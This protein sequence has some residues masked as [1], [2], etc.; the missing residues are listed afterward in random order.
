[1]AQFSAKAAFTAMVTASRFNTGRAPGKPRHTGQTLELG[2]SPKW[3]ESEQKIFVLVRS[4]RWTSRPITA[5]YLVRTTVET[6]ISRFPY[7]GFAS[8]ADYYTRD[9]PAIGPSGH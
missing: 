5:S 1:M 2:G 3:V 7:C 4:C 8:P 6:V 9:F